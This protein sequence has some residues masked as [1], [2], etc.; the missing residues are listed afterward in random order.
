MRTNPVTEAIA[1]R[2]AWRRFKPD[3][4]EPEVL[5]AIVHAGLRAPSAS[6]RTGPLLAV[7]QDARI[8]E[9]MGRANRAASRERPSTEDAFVSRE[10]PSILDDT[11]IKSGF[12]GAP[13]VVT[14]FAPRDFLYSAMDCACAAENMMIA[15][16]SFGVGSCFVGRAPASLGCAQ[17]RELLAATGIPPTHRAFAHVVLGY[18]AT[19]RP[20]PKPAKRQRV[21]LVG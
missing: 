11:S 5:E 19:E 13:C 14:L 8:N 21:W 18:P 6:G 17:G 4:I 20:Q 1:N 9:A 3:R 10:Q 12:Y 16:E 2:R 15:A 7:C